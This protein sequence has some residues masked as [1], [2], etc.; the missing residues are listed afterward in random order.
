[1]RQEIKWLN[2]AIAAKDIVEHMTYYHVKNNLIAATNGR[3]TAGYPWK[4]DGEF[5]VPGDELEKVLERLPSDPKVTQKDHAVT[6]R[7]G[8]FHSTITT[9]PASSWTYPGVDDA[10]WQK[11]PDDLLPVLTDIRNFISDNA[12][13]PWAMAVALEGG[14]AYASNNVSIASARCEGTEGMSSMLPSWAVDFVLKRQKDLV[15]WSWTDH[16]VG[17][18]WAN[19]AWMRSCLVDSKFPETA[20][21]LAREAHEEHPTQEITD[22]FR[23]ALERV[24]SIAEDA[25]QV[26]ADRVTSTFKQASVEEITACEVPPEAAF[27]AWGASFLATVIRYATHWQPSCWPK[28]A[29]WRGERLAGY[30]VGRR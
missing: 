3:L 15:W 24:A 8:R 4:Y 6:L 28:P 14:W 22:Q 30:I 2:D 17:F 29:P 21:K 9:L 27:S 12:V 16:Y 5:L 20:A 10:N 25:I 1:M 23:E 11:L 19:G 7:C 26:Y 18:M 13:Q